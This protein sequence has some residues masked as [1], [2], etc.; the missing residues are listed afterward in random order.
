MNPQKIISKRNYITAGILFLFGVLF[1]GTVGIIL[2]IKASKEIDDGKPIFGTIIPAGMLLSL[3]LYTFYYLLSITPKITITIEGIEFKTIFKTN[4]YY[5]TEVE[6]IELTG[7]KP[8]KFLFASMPMEATTIT[9]REGYDKLIWTDNYRNTAIIRRALD[10]I[11]KQ[12]KINQ[13]LRII[14]TEQD[15]LYSMDTDPLEDN[16][17]VY[18][19]NFYLSMNGIIIIGWL[20][21]IGF[22]LVTR[23]HVFLSNFGA[24]LSISFATIVFCGSSINQVYYF[25]ITDQYLY[26]RNHVLPW[27]N[28]SIELNK[29]KE[30]VIESPGR[31]STSLRIID[32]DFNSKIY[33]A[34]TLSVKTWKTLLAE[35]ERRSIPVR[36]ETEL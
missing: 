21:L 36:L 33:G 15:K 5:W 25:I 20:G 12:L 18:K 30:A 24:I 28:K 7:K 17:E 19:G 8:M 2:L 26:V 32:K 1:F 29:I 14:F 27:I 3:A 31:R 13:P 23:P 4:F 9:L 11:N 22:G 35:L 34:G 6:S 10:T 16:G